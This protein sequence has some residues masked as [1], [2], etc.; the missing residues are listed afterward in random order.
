MLLV[1]VVVGLAMGA[2]GVLSEIGRRATATEDVVVEAAAE[3]DEEVVT[4]TDED[5]SVSVQ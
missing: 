5:T 1:V 3:M 4:E 2:V